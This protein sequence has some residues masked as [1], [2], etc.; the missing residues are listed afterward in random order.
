MS[1][2]TFKGEALFQIA[3]KILVGED[4]E[5]FVMLHDLF[6]KQNNGLLCCRRQHGACK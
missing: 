3:V 6:D 4:P 5:R 1:F 2:F